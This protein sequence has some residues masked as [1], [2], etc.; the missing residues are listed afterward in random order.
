MRS[1]QSFARSS[2][3]RRSTSRG[4]CDRRW[5][6]GA[7]GPMSVIEF[8]P[9]VAFTAVVGV[10]ERLNP[11]GSV[12]CDGCCRTCKSQPHC[13]QRM[14]DV[15]KTLGR[16]V[17]EPRHGTAGRGDRWYRTVYDAHATPL[18]DYFLRR[19]SQ[20]HAYDLVAEV[21][22]IAWRRRAIAPDEPELRPWLF[23]VARNVLRNHHRGA[24]RRMRLPKA[25]PASTGPSARR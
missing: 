24:A 25:P 14:N 21:F 3:L 22:L 13:G 18:L 1:L 15:M 20:D 4:A 9:V 10:D 16:T 19:V 2:L 6:L 7:I 23:R 17:M 12:L 11:G 5:A 8:E